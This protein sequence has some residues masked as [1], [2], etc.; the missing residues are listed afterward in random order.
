MEKMANFFSFK[1]SKTSWIVL[2]ILILAAFLRLYHISDYMIF[3]GDEGRDVLTAY[4]ILHGKLTLLGPTSSVG[5]FFLGPIYYYMMAPFLWLF[6]YNPVGPSVMVAILG[7][8][9]VYLVYLFSKEFFGEKAGIIASA[10]YATS[11]IVIIF[12]RSSWNP[13]VFPFFTILSLYVIYK[14]VL[15]NNYWLFALSG[16]FMG[17]NL[18]IHYLA[19]FVGAVMFFYVLFAGIKLKNSIISLLKQYEFLFLG[20]IIGFLPFIAFEARH[21]FTNSQNILRFIFS[22]S[23]TG[24]SGQFI[25]QIKFVL[26][27]LFGGVLINYPSLFDFSKYDRN[28]LSVWALAVYSIEIILIGFFLWKFWKNFRDKDKYRKYLLIFV[29]GLV[30]I[31]LF[32]LYKRSIY[33]YYLGFLFPLP[34]IL[35]GFAFSDIWD[36]FKIPGKIVAI[37]ILTSILIINFNFSPIKTPGN[38][39][40]KQVK[41]VS[42]FILSK[43]D[44][45]PF[46]FAISGAGNSDFAYRYFFKLE[47][48]DPVRI[49]GI[50]VDPKRTSVTDQLFVVCEKVPCLPLGESSNDIAG[51][52]RGEIGGDWNVSVLKIYKLVHYS[53]R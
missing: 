15:K 2:I 46:N 51:F 1:A 14:A 22:S 13:N 3:L 17:I 35:L 11:P 30:G 38:Q 41:S 32:G 43:T 50:N 16:F 40:I 34:F 48:R 19:T 10:V 5:G 4:S 44:G 42:D 27:R 6:D 28:L 18:Q 49:L 37:I 21:Q 23:E 8:A 29:W 39:Q 52:G 47:G 7:V 26:E 36:K 9:T 33:D 24:A 12:S 31:G 53:G 45:K 25:F 20:F